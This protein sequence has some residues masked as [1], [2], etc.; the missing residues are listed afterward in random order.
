MHTTRR[1]QRGTRALTGGVLLAVAFA[2]APHPV[3]AGEPTAASTQE[4]TAP[5][6]D[7]AVG[8]TETSPT[9]TSTAPSSTEHARPV[10]AALAAAHH[11][12][13]G[14]GLAFVD[15]VDVNTDLFYDVSDALAKVIAFLSDPPPVDPNGVVDP[16]QLLATAD[17]LQRG[18]DPYTPEPDDVLATAD[19]VVQT[20]ES[21]GD[22]AERLKARAQEV[23]DGL[24]L[25]VAQQLA[26][27]AA[28]LPTTE[29]VVE[30]ARSI[31]R[32]VRGEAENA[33]TV[34]ADL[35]IRLAQA[36]AYLTDDQHQDAVR[37]EVTTVMLTL[38]HTVDPLPDALAPTTAA[39]FDASGSLVAWAE[40][41][42]QQGIE[43]PGP[44]YTE[45][46][47]TDEAMPPPNGDVTPVDSI[48]VADEPVSVGAPIA[49][50]KPYPVAGDVGLPGRDAVAANSWDCGMYTGED[51]VPPV[52][53][54]GGRVIH[55]PIVRVVLVGSWWH[56]AADLRNGVDS[57]FG[58]M[59]GSGYQGI[60][61]Q[62]WDYSG[63]ISDEMHYQGT[64]II[65]GTPPAAVST[66]RVEGYAI[67]A[68]RERVGWKNNPSVIWFV[69]L[70]PS[71]LATY[72]G[73]EDKCG[74]QRLG[75]TGTERYV[76]AQ[77]DYPQ[78]ACVRGSVR[79]SLT[80][81]AAHEYV[82]AVTNP[83]GQGWRDKTG[84]HLPD[85][86]RALLIAGPGGETV[87][88]VWSNGDRR[89]VSS[90]TPRFSYRVTAVKQADGD[91]G[92][93]SALTRGHSYSGA[94]V[95]VVN[96]GNMPW[97][98]YGGK[99][100][101]LATADNQCSPFA[102]VSTAG[103]WTNCRR[104]S[105]RQ[106]RVEAGDS[107]AFTFSLKPD[108]SLID[109]TANHVETFRLIAGSTWMTDTGSTSARLT[110]IDLQMFNAEPVSPPT[111][112]FVAY[113]VHGS[114]AKV[115]VAL[116]NT[117]T[118]YWYPREVMFL[119]TDA[120]SP[121]AATSWPL[122]PGS[123]RGCR[124]HRFDKLTPPGGI[125][126]FEV[127]LRLPASD[128]ALMK[129]ADFFPYAD[130]RRVADGQTSTKKVSEQRVVVR[131]VIVPDPVSAHAVT[132]YGFT[133]GDASSTPV[134]ESGFS[135]LAAAGLDSEWTRITSCRASVTT[136]YGAY[137]YEAP[138]MTMGG[139]F[140]WTGALW[141][142]HTP[143][144]GDTVT[145]CWT[146]ESTFLDGTTADHAGCSS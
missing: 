17:E 142:G 76:I 6:S 92:P 7:P 105:L 112:G 71:S 59:S 25:W 52:E 110:D 40:A 30:L 45:N 134:D 58:S 95:A 31:E 125:Y 42:A 23:A 145:V 85:L 91:A 83:D 84:Q 75:T 9:D 113:G 12:D 104:I 80:R 139:R 4:S 126:T 90:F 124:A 2:L 146:A 56:G 21:L 79:A 97:L 46:T 61:R 67:R 138:P 18:L 47:D 143:A 82:G 49:I 109:G 100:T 102:D 118:A 119:G 11:A 106:P 77:V 13:S 44:F 35:L 14:I 15:G 135:C 48:V 1:K 10:L 107:T 54:T 19:Q 130:V 120:P 60:L 50:T 29:Q 89:C 22:D 41:L 16:E 65:E 88:K 74:Y 117:G 63:Y 70:P 98:S 57:L 121:F 39:A 36:T 34:A 115:T 8:F 93:G 33:A 26:D 24:T 72:P 68:A 62:Y 133:S 38:A 108:G 86:C 55:K 3:Y 78:G 128:K 66:D 37:N 73:T 123:C 51:C 53:L 87:S 144:S 116:R 96:T 137:S 69:M 111:L 28:Q 127:T 132:G 81:T 140:A 27:V 122:G 5:A 101:Y 64:H 131:V 43:G 99:K 103:L 129:T 141:T 136:A 114:D 32:V 94:S 20:A